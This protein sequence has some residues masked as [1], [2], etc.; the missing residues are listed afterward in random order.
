MEEIFAWKE[1]KKRPAGGPFERGLGN[2]GSAGG[3]RRAFFVG[4][5]GERGRPLG[6][7]GRAWAGV[8][9]HIY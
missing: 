5:E 3:C 1:G 6:G 2:K 4:V 8:F 7:E 9:G